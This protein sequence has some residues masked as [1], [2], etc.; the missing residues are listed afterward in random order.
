MLHVTP[1]MM[2]HTY[3]LLNVTKPFRRWKLAHPDEVAFVVISANDRGGDYYRLKN[4]TH[5]IRINHR[6]IGSLEKLQ[7]AIAHEMVHMH[8][9]I[10][11]P[12]DTAHH[13]W[14]FNQAAAQV[15][16]HHVWDFNAF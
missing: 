3:R 10:D 15:C 6:W 4:G 9:E 14:R 12:N 5:R 8:L 16:R 11:C 2:E 7:R 1:D 13:G